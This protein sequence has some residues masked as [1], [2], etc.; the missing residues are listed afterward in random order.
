MTEL[1]PGATFSS[2]GAS[3]PGSCGKVGPNTK[4]KLVDQET[5]ETLP[6]GVRGELC[7]K[8]PQVMKGYLKSPE[9]TADTMEVK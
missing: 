9:A 2:P 7:V 6:A 1:S 5:R 3:V 8:G 4:V